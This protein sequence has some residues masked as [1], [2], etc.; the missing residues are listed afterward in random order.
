MYLVFMSS[1]H[2][3]LVINNMSDLT[4]DLQRYKELKPL[5][6]K[7]IDDVFDQLLDPSET[8]EKMTIDPRLKG[9]RQLE[10]SLK[11][12]ALNSN[13]ANISDHTL[14]RLFHELRKVA[15]DENIDQDGHVN[16]DFFWK[17][18]DDQNPHQIAANIAATKPLVSLNIIPPD[19]ESLVSET[20]KAYCVG[21]PTACISLC[22][23]SVERVIVDIAIRT[24][25]ITDEDR[26]GRMGMCDRISL[27]I[28]RSVSN[29][30]PLRQ[31]INA[32]MASTSDVIHSN[33]EASMPLALQIYHKAMQLI[34][35]L[36]G[37]YHKQFKK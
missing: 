2:Q 4:R 10:R 28:D 12:A 34:Q 37:H 20:R 11:H 14:H 7:H 32:F 36:Y 22:R 29:T 33:T 31:D 9:F 5:W 15:L 1:F 13:A 27:L 24:E 25:R 19:V 23:S 16:E 17:V 21:L 18:V 26:L 3:F 35:S 6:I 30:S 8:A